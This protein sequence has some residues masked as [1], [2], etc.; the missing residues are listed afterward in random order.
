MNA[1]ITLVPLLIIRFG[2][3]GIIDRE[4]LK[5]AAYFAPLVGGEKIAY[6]IYQI[7]NILLF[8]YLC[9]LR[10]TDNPYWLYTGLVLFILGIFLCVA[11][12]INFAKP[13]KNGINQK[14]LYRISRNPIYVAYFVYFLSCVI[15][16]QS[17]ILLF[18]LVVYQISAHWIIKSEERWCEEKFGEE[19][20][21]YKNKVR[22]YL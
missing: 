14:G 19:Y 21:S 15:L 3:L 5:R 11:S 6:L 7:S 18:L 20:I 1:I 2:L 22:R 8:V 13:D 12:I 17:T 4:A 9:F 16:T 10:I